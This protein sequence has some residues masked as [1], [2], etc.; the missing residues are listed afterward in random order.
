MELSTYQKE[1]RESLHSPEVFWAK[2]AEKI[3]WFEKWHSVQSGTNEHA[4]WFLG[5]KLNLSYNCLDRHIKAG[6]GSKTA[7]LEVTEGNTSREISYQDLLEEVERLAGSLTALGVQKGDRVALYLPLTHHIIVAMLACARIGAVHVVVFAGFSANALKVRLDSTQAKVLIT[8]TYSQRRGKKVPLLE[9]AREASAASAFLQNTIV[10][11]REVPQ[12]LTANEHDWEEILATAPPHIAPVALES[13]DPLFLLHTSGTTG[14]PK[15]ILHT[16]AGYLLDAMLTNQY[17]LDLKET[18]TLWCT[19]DP[20]WITGHTYVCYGPLALGATIVLAEGAPEY[21]T[22]DRWWALIA[23]HRV[24]ILYTAPTA[25][26]MFRKM[27]EEWP[28]KHDLSSLRLLGSVGEPLNPEAREWYRKHIGGERCEVI[29]T[30]WQTE[31]GSHALATLPGILQKPGKTGLPFFGIEPA[32]VDAV[33]RELPADTIGNLVLKRSWPSALRGCWNH[34]EKY[35]EYWNTFPGKYW[36]GDL[37]HI[38]EEGYVQIHG[39][40]DDVINIAGHRIG[41]AEVESALVAHPQVAEAAAV[42]VPDE[43]L[44]QTLHLYVVLV[45][46]HEA[47]TELKNE[48]SRHIQNEIGRFL[49]LDRI[50]FVDS[51]PKTRSG[52]IM[53]RVLRA[54]ALGEDPGDT[55]TQ[56]E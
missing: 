1:Y 17:V 16:Q 43:I 9:T 29:D 12:P 4:T 32:V 39:R 38:D 24:T 7:L 14:I 51:L 41:T 45:P 46:L 36:T 20:G 40:A 30:W 22:P 11:R 48:L 44:G 6:K 35:F 15:A 50:E 25:I 52:K 53:R 26:R 47:T 8:A 21:P 54:L 2:H 3:S 19:A 55:S 34:E 42:A 23:K 37:A 5:G 28:A 56:E 33:G 10:W 18:D 49:K 31:T 13:E 27:G